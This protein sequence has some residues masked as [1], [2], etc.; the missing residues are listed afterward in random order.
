MPAGWCWRKAGSRSMS[1]A[2]LA[3]R[4]QIAA[5]RRQS[6]Y[7][8]ARAN[9]IVPE[10]T[11]AGNA[12][13]VIIAIMSFLACLTLGAVTLVRDASREWQ[14]DI[15]QEVTIQVRPMACLDAA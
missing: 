7:S 12:L 10:S 11:V 15:Q 1:E 9:Q 4:L 8:T 5:Y 2:D 3:H 14:L 13:T 6:R